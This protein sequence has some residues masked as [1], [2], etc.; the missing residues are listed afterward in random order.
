MMPEWLWL[1]GASALNS[2]LRRQAQ[3]RKRHISRGRLA[4]STSA[5]SGLGSSSKDGG[6]SQIVSSASGLSMKTAQESLSI[7]ATPEGSSAQLAQSAS[8][9]SVEEA[10]RRDNSATELGLQESEGV[11]PSAS[12]QSVDAV[13]EEGAM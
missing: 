1:W 11:T 12:G 13:Q 3:V 2:A 9:V 8:G 5:L 7:G 6:L 10:G 4:P